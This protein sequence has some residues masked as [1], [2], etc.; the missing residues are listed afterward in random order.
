MK[1]L[2]S[3]SQTRSVVFWAS[4]AIIIAIVIASLIAKESIDGLFFMVRSGA[5]DQMGWL[6][7]GTTSGILLFSLWLLNSKYGDIRLGPDGSEPDFG[8]P[9]WFAM[10]FSAGMGIGLL[11]YSVAEPLLHMSHPVSSLPG[12]RSPALAAMGIT[13]FHW[14]VHPWSI[15]AVVGLCLAFFSFRRGRPLS[16]RSALHPLF[17]DRVNG[18]IGDVVDVL[19]VVSTL[20]GVA[21]SLGLGALQVN[22]G[23][24][25]VFGVT[26]SPTIQLIIIACITAVAT[27]SVVSG[28]DVGVRRLSEINMVLAAGLLGFVFLAGPTIFLVG[29][30]I[31]NLGEYIQRLVS[32]SLWTARFEADNIQQWLG[33]WTIFYWAWWIS[34][35]PFV[36]MFVARVS[37]GRTLK[38]F[39]L[40]V[41]LAPSVAGFVWLTV[42]GDTA[43]YL[44]MHTQAPL[45]ETVA[46]AK[47]L[48]TAVFVLLEQLPISGVTAVVCTT[49]II[50]F[51]VTS[52]DSASLV[53]DTIASGGSENPPV[54]QRIYWALLE[55]LVAALLL[56]AGG[57]Q[58][59]QAAAIATAL[60]FCLVIVLMCW[61]LIR[62]L[63]EELV[64][65]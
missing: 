55:G 22:A 47:T 23:L 52:S 4:S 34:W 51:F 41:L 43:L 24:K 61:S 58:A 48:P 18:W 40:A 60:P 50:L 64:N 30:F 26:E 14:G 44:E 1:V 11:F 35:A 25:H 62:A 19:A 57:L 2:K 28:L 7:V 5:V 21:T 15:Y 16:I 12:S 63:R 9:T 38:E 6:Y 29:A 3:S 31:D 65:I 10:L 54:W 27:V 17:G 13:W 49:C 42:F 8:L 59:L 46:E 37:R 33:D 53:I 32:H 36:G 20:F 45:S 56:I 39:M